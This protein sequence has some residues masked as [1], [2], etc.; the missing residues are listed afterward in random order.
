MSVSHPV[1]AVR[2]MSLSEDSAIRLAIPLVNKI[3]D[4]FA[5]SGQAIAFD[6]PQIVV[7]G[8][9]SVGKSSVL[10][11]FVGR[12]FLPRGSGIVTRRPLVLQLVKTKEGGD[13]FGMFTH[14][15]EKE[16]YDFSEIR[17]EIEAETAR[18]AGE[19]KFISSVPIN[20]K[21]YSPH[22]VDLT[23]VDLPG[24]TRVPVGD[25]PENI[26]EIVRNMIMSFIEKENCL[27]LAVTPANT[28]LAT[29]DAIMLAQK[30]DP[31]GKRTIGVLSKLDLM[32]QGTDAQE[33]LENKVLYLERGYIGVVN[34][35]QKDIQN[36][37]DLSSALESEREFFE[38]H[39][40]YQHFA[41]VQGTDYLRKFLNMELTEHIRIKMPE[42]QERIGLEAL[43]LEAELKQFHKK[44]EDLTEFTKL[45]TA[46]KNNVEG[47]FQKQMGDVS[48]RL[49]TVELEKRCVGSLI[50]GLFETTFRRDIELSSAIDDIQIRYKILMAK[51][52][53]NG[54]R[55]SMFTS[56]KVLETIVEEQVSRLSLPIENIV[57]T[58]VDQL[59][60]TIS[61]LI[62]SLPLMGQF[63][64]MQR[65]ACAKSIEELQRNKGKALDFIDL[66]ILIEKGYV[67][68]K[69][70]KRRTRSC[71]KRAFDLPQIVVVGSQ[72]VGKSSVLEGFVGREFLPRGSGIVTRRPLV[73]QLVKTKEG[74][75]ELGMF[76][77][78][79]EQ[80]FYDFSEICRE[81]E[82]ETARLAGQGKFISDVPINLKIYSPNVVDLTL[83]DLP[84]LTRVP[85]GDQPANVEEIVTKMIL[86]FIEK[87][88]CL[89]LA[90]TPANTD[91]A[92]SDAI[93][94]AQKMDPKGERTIGVLSK[95]DL[96]DQGTDARDILENNV[97][98]LKRGGSK[99]TLKTE[100]YFP[101]LGYIGIVNR[102]Q[103]D[104]VDG[105]NLFSAF[106]AEKDFFIGHPAYQHMAEVQ[107]T[108]YLRRYLNKELTEHI[109]LKMPEVQEHIKKTAVLLEE[110]LKQYHEKPEDMRGFTR[111]ATHM[112]NYVINEFQKRMGDVSSRLDSVQLNERCMGSIIRNLFDDH[113]E[114]SSTIDDVEMRY[115]ILMARENTNGLRA[116]FFT[117]A[118]VFE[119]IVEDQVDRLSKPAHEAVD[120]VV[121]ELE[122]TI[123]SLFRSMSQ[124][125]ILERFACTK[126]IE[127]LEENANK[128]HGHINTLLRVEKAYV[129]TK[130][131]TIQDD[132]DKD[133]IVMWQNED[134]TGRAS[135]GNYAYQKIRLE[136]ERL[137]LFNYPRDLENSD[138]HVAIDLRECCVRIHNK[139]NKKVE[140]VWR[141]SKSNVA[142]FDLSQE[143]VKNLI[144]NFCRVGF[145]PKISET[146]K[147]VRP[148]KED[149]ERADD[150]EVRQVEMVYDMIREYMDVV[151]RS[152]WSYIP[153]IVI[154]LVIDE[155]VDYFKTDLL[156]DLVLEGIVLMHEAPTVAKDRK[157]KQKKLLLCKKILEVCRQLEHL[158][159]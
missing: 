2:V 139:H 157:T 87:E 99:L 48:S 82:A 5:R 44:P 128:A 147:R 61:S 121:E 31:K 11:G 135:Y 102:S 58:V 32:D 40:V 45:A 13:E 151:I 80:E 144:S 23:L 114:S 34:R 104:I 120:N 17:R 101:C 68:T 71:G 42:L 88:N 85:V 142:S 56:A 130:H 9:Q 59:E 115:T 12:E 22:V 14:T 106:E 18:E 125:P 113:I 35:S 111:L 30:V 93:K 6:L 54:V 132:I 91:L 95:L 50:R 137:V 149:L 123:R 117:S 84:G 10:E 155:Q 145:Y 67:G 73:L 127:K 98:P 141:R 27:I 90:V 148:E 1:I 38:S 20:L 24:L 154:A 62:R 3:Q 140:V 158:S 53:T 75:D 103:K 100:P 70:P 7:V 51:E 41:A 134:G 77:H 64:A 47:E 78:T 118:K 33:I 138:G 108:E 81:I 116:G 94:L 76:T 109:K 74:G 72:S 131:R 136:K 122:G 39:P 8:S 97:L 49:D 156:S 124:F 4:F 110:E 105:K 146:G 29:S 57:N 21:I 86:S 36:D 25:Q 26:E 150:V 15:E 79:G 112:M 55:D 65:F 83:V 63:P 43:W 152:I 52:N 153:K 28:D 16:F 129:G 89:I 46:V 159:V 92:T 119:T 143:D 69:Q 126:S 19:G 60:G 37:K 107:G 133:G 66:R 96:M